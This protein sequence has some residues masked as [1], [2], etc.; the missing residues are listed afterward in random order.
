MLLAGFAQSCRSVVAI[1]GKVL[2]LHFHLQQPAAGLSVL[3]SGGVPELDT[4]S[5]RRAAC[6]KNT[7]RREA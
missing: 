1:D 2:L 7:V 5:R 4:A 3:A 6:L